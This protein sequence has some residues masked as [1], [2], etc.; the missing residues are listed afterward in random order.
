MPIPGIWKKKKHDKKERGQALILIV[1]SIIGLIGVAALAVDGGN[2]YLEERRTQNAADTIALGGALARIKGQNWVAATYKIAES[3]GFSNDGETNSVQVFSPPESGPYAGD[4]EYIQVRI[5]SQVETYFAGVIGIPQITVS[6]EAI[7]RTKAS[8][9]KEILEGNAIISL[10]PTSDCD[11]ERAFWV[12]GESTLSISGG[13]IFINSN[14]PDCALF[15]NGNGSIRID[16]GEIS[17]VGGARIQKPK[18]LTPYPPRTN[19]APLAYPPPFF[20]PE[21]GCAGKTAEILEDGITMSPGNYGEDVF[22]PEGIQFL[23]AGVYCLK[24]D[25]VL[26][27]ASLQGSNV[28]FILEY[29]AI[30]WSPSSFIDLGAPQSGDRAGLLIFAPIENKNMMKI[31]SNGDSVLRGTILMPGAEI[32]LNGGDSKYGYQSQIIGYRIYSNGQSNII[33]KY[34]DEQN[35]DTFSMPEIQLIK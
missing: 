33:I 18:L 14:N 27:N 32:R 3:N 6:S 34:K 24:G 21:I 26:E 15:T 11:N 23:E 16:G 22:P 13:G 5:T 8:E 31:N 12:H 4:V 25:F 29:G 17:I 10:A 20:M 30:D 7:A 1:F 19:S 9:I 2:A 28:T 35:Y